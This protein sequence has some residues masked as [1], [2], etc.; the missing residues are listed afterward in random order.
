MAKKTLEERFWERVSPE[1]N[2]GCWLWTG[3]YQTKNGGYG[4]LYDSPGRLRYAHA[5]AW[6]LYRGP[7]PEGTE[8]DHLCRVTI[9]VNPD[10]LEPVTHRENM[11]RGKAPSAVNNRKTHC[12]RGHEFTAENTMHIKNGDRRC[13]A[14]LKLPHRREYEKAY[15]RLPHRRAYDNA[16]QRA[17]KREKYWRMKNNDPS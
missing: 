10:H 14:C 12:I 5:I 17:Y 11:L 13:R 16:Y 9:C 2:S 15:K 3:A 4:R 6:E 1:P 8:I 7:I